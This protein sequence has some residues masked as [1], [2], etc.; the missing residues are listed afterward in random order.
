MGVINGVHQYCQAGEGPTEETGEG[1]ITWEAGRGGR[2][3]DD[4]GSGSDCSAAW[5]EGNTAGHRDDDEGGGGGL[6]LGGHGVDSS[7][8]T[9]WAC[10]ACRSTW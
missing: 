5:H 9:L 2:C 6:R 8:R 7:L 4:Q 3:N 1:D 10:C